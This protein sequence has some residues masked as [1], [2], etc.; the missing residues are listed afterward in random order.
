MFT[1]D[2]LGVVRGMNSASV[3]LIYLVPPFNSNRDY[4]APVGSEAAG[5]A[6]KDTRT[7]S[8]IDLAWHGL[9]AE[10]EPAL[11]AIVDATGRSHGSGMKSYLI[12]MAVRLLE[13]RRL[14]KETGSIYSGS[15]HER[16]TIVR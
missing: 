2:N 12:M 5:A 6:F 14:L 13:M 7:L 11:Y 1:G 16:E 4:A 9:I 15:P 3:D 10:A 8:D